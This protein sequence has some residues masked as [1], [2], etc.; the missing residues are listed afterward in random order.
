M[1]SSKIRTIVPCVLAV[2]FFA[3]GLWML[4]KSLGQV[5]YY[6]RQITQAQQALQ[7]ADPAKAD[8]VEQK[9]T[10]LQQQNQE[11][12]DQ[13]QALQQ[14]NGELEESNAQLSAQLEELTGLEQTAYYQKVL[15]SLTE[16]MD[17]VEEYISNP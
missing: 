7:E 5:N 9:A 8:A 1:K 12:T 3:A 10:A 15:E 13:V 2:L 11:L 6:N 16:G 17:Q 14:E 4:A